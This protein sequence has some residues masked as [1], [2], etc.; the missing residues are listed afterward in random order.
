MRE[1]RAMRPISIA[2]SDDP[3]DSSE[4]TDASAASEFLEQVSNCKVVAESRFVQLPRHPIPKKLLGEVDSF[5]AQTTKAFSGVHL[6]VMEKMTPS[7]MRALEQ[8]ACDAS[9]RLSSSL[10]SGQRY[11]RRRA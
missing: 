11:R 7:V 2:S 10:R 6:K 4:K 9:H 5:V 3:R 1:L 8:L